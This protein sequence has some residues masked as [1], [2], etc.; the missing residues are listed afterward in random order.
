MEK[1][2]ILCTKCEISKSFD[3]GKIPKV[4]D[5]KKVSNKTDNTILFQIYQKINNSQLTNKSKLQQ[6]PFSRCFEPG[7]KFMILVDGSRYEIEIISKTN[8]NQEIFLKQF[9]LHY[10]SKQGQLIPVS[11]RFVKICC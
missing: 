8:K 9:F 11:V 2:T 7:R 4:F 3:I 10:D 5:F 1:S 6:F